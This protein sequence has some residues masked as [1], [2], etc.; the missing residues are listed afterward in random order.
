MEALNTIDS[1]VSKAGES[2]HH[3]T[4]PSSPGEAQDKSKGKANV[5]K[6][7]KNKKRRYEGERNDGAIIPNEDYNRARANGHCTRCGPGKHLAEDC[8]VDGIC[9]RSGWSKT[10]LWPC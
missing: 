7:N 9:C 6:P 5:S 4:A 8:R 2:P 10:I 3:N 1:I